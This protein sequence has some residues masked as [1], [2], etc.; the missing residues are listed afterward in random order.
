MDWLAA[1][2]PSEGTNATRPRAGSLAR[3][4]APTCR[5]TDR[6]GEVVQ[7]VQALGWDVCLVVND[8]Q[9]VLGRVRASLAAQDPKALVETVMESGPGTIRPDTELKSFV[10]RMRRRKVGS[11]IVTNSDGQLMGVLYREDIERFLETC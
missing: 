11:A 6:V 3:R 8:A 4:D 7:R 5:L 9:V 2:L 10:E 1:G